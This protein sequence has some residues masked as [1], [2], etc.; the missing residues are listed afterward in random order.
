MRFFSNLLA[1]SQLELGTIGFIVYAILMCLLWWDK[2]FSVEHTIDMNCPYELQD[3]MYK[4]LQDMFETRYGS[5]FLSPT[6]KVLI[7]MQRIP[8]WAYMSHFGL[9]QSA[10]ITALQFV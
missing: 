5:R 8:K 10:L 6:R 9:G 1:F 3:E 4:L 2:S 7:K